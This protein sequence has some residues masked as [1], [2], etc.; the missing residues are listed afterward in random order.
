MLIAAIVWS[1]SFQVSNA[2]TS[3]APS[4]KGWPPVGAWAVI[5]FRSPKTEYCSVTSRL[6]PNGPAGFGMS[7]AINSE[8]THFYLEY[9][10]PRIPTPATIALSADGAP[11]ASLTVLN[12]SSEG[13]QNDQMIVADVPGYD[14][15][16]HST[17]HEWT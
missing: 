7:F 14:G 5:L 10:G 9:Q 12:Q 16:I 3:G 17:R 1:N 6:P 4:F 2:Q 11:I 15:A 13:D 8:T